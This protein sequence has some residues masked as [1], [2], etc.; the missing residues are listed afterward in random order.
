MMV[1]KGT[2]KKGQSMI[3][4][5]KHFDGYTLNDVY[6]K[7]S[8]AKFHAFCDCVLKAEAEKGRNFH[9]CSHNTFNFSVAW[10]VENGMR[11]ETACNSYLVLYPEYCN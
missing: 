7:Y 8:P 11:I 5:A 9:V 10:E 2:T 1:I 4:S 3:E 6:G